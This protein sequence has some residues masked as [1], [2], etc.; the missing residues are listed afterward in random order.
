MCWVKYN[1]VKSWIGKWKVIIKI[2]IRIEIGRTCLIKGSVWK[3]NWRE[4]WC[5]SN[6][7]W[8]VKFVNITL[9]IAACL[10]SWEID[11]VETIRI[12][13]DLAEFKGD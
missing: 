13:T 7:N 11:W 6:R 8:I 3:V 9:N 10:R 2:W 5:A 1:L 4:R 12:R